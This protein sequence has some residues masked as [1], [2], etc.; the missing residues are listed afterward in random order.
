MSYEYALDPLNSL[1]LTLENKRIALMESDEFYT[2][3]VRAVVAATSQQTTPRGTYTQE[4]W[5][6]PGNDAARMIPEQK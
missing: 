5:E 1:A 3:S 2:V 6:Q 4:Q